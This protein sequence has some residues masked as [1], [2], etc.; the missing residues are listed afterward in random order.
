[1]TPPSDDTRCAPSRR[2]A[3]ARAGAA[4][5]PPA[6]V[7]APPPDA[8]TIPPTARP[9]RRAHIAA[10]AA[11]LAVAGILGGLTVDRDGAL[12]GD[13]AYV[14]GGDVVT[15]AQFRWHLGVVEAL[16]GAGP[17]V[18]DPQRDRYERDVAHA[19]VVSLVL[20]A[21]ARRRGLVVSDADV[22][23]ALAAHR[24]GRAGVAE[25]DMRAELRRRLAAEAL[26][27]Q[28]VSGVPAVTDGELRRAYLER[29]P[30]SAERRRLLNIVV[31]SRER[32]EEVLAQARAGADW[33]WLAVRYSRDDSTRDTGGELGEPSADELEGPYAAAAFAAGAGEF[34][35]PVRT[36][37]GWNVGQVVGVQA[38]VPVPFELVGEQF[39]AGLLAERRAA[40][41]QGFVR[42]QVAA[43]AVEYAP[44]YRPADPS[45][46]PEPPS[47]AATGG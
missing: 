22:D 38:A 45:A 7:R 9:R 29:P 46:A 28:V 18:A 25:A 26:R 21:E 33:G 41:W 12:P 11:G 27:A 23:R 32:A 10:A 8:R 17:P 36:R 15:E 31:E 3:A 47:V 1:M 13:A 40:A 16:D 2:P 42:Q 14:V 43:V 34:F 24:P 6:V 39:R 44:R 20:G 4:G 19:A 30:L 37:A 35:G 5:V